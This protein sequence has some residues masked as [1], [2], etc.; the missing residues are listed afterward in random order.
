MRMSLLIFLVLA[1]LVALGAGTAA[2]LLAVRTRQL[3]RLL[4]TSRNE[5]DTLNSQVLA[6]RRQIQSLQASVQV[7]PVARFTRRIFPA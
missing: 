7:L 2:A 6:D 1:I 4:E 5:I 3:A